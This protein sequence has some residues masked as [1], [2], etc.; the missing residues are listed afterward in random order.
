ME[1]GAQNRKLYRENGFF[2]I[3]DAIQ[4]PYIEALYKDALGIFN[5]YKDGIGGAMT[6]ELLQDFYE[7]DFEAFQNCCK[8]LQNLPSMYS[9]ASNP[10]MLE[11]LG[12][13]ADL[14][15]PVFATRPVMMVN[16]LLLG[17]KYHTIPLHKDSE[18]VQG[19]S[20][21]AVAWMPIAPITELNGPLQIISGSHLWNMDHADLND[22][23]FAIY[24]DDQ[25]N[26]EDAILQPGDLLLFN[27]DLLHKSGTLKDNSQIRWSCHFRYNDLE[28]E[29]F[30]ERGFPYPYE[31]KPYKLEN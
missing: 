30:I 28:D 24:K 4:K 13:I 22:E 27:A 20:N 17:D 14:V 19:S 31:Y 21:C 29:Q 5:I 2:V 8:Q 11:Y 16:N 25:Y 9:L 6:V 3:E 23:G 18:S 1:I 7:E 26:F 12:I 10:V 15:N